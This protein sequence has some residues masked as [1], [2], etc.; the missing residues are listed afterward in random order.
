MQKQFYEYANVSG[1]PCIN[2]VNTP[3]C[4]M[5]EEDPH[6]F[7]IYAKDRQDAF[8]LA[9][10]HLYENR[11]LQAFYGFYNG[12]PYHGDIQCIM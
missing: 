9:M 6:V 12:V 7:L 2:Q 3:S 11:P 5:G 4:P 1:Y 8:R 10:E